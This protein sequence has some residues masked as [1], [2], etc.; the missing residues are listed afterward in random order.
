MLLIVSSGCN[1]TNTYPIDFFSE[2]HYSK[3]WHAEEPPRLDSP[4]NAIQVNEKTLNSLA[5]G[6][7]VQIGAAEPANYTLDEAKAVKNP[8]QPTDANLKAG[9]ALFAINCTQCHGKAGLG[10]DTPA[11][12]IA[13]GNAFML[14]YFNSVNQT[15][16]AGQKLT[17]PADLTKKPAV[18]N[19]SDGEIYYYLSN[20][21]SKMPP[22]GNLLTPEERWQ[23]ILHIRQIEGK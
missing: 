22:F 6:P 18:T 10:E 17:L 7:L 2:M 4:A 14:N 21:L 5:Y 23:L 3:S 9:A 15:L 1:S 19:A 8:L 16:P 13:A 11:D 12:Q 20:G